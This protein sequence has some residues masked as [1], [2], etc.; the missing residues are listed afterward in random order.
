ML[1]VARMTQASFDAR[2]DAILGRIAQIMGVD[3]SRLRI[4][5]KNAAKPADRRLLLIALN[6]AE[7]TSEIDVTVQDSTSSGEVAAVKQ[8]VS[9]NEAVSAIQE[10]SAAQ[11][12]SELGVTVEAVEVVPTGAPT[13]PPTSAPSQ[14]ALHSRP[15]P[16][17]TQPS[18]HAPNS[19]QGL[20]TALMVMAGAVVS[21]LLIV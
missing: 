10:Q 1:R 8:N 17:A 7:G 4:A 21:L 9:T 20:S 16:T 2:K 6:E 5:L 15:L 19:A 11:L 13:L 14:V 3:I 12:S 18:T